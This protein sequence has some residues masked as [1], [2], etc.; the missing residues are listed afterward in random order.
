MLKTGAQHVES[1]RDG[2]SV[3]ID[4]ERVADV[5]THPAFRNAVASIATLFDFQCAPENRAL[6]SYVTEAGEPVSRAWQLPTSYAALVERR[7]GLEA[8][9]DLHYGFLNRTPDYVASGISAMVMGLD[10]FEAY[11]RK[12]AGA[13]LDYYRHARDH[14]LYLNYVITNPQADR[15]KSAG[16]QARELFTAGMVDQDHEGITVR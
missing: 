14:N 1:L 16:S 10:V 11:D 13:L 2:R 15:S 3:Y 12:R 7:K 4:G 6:L 9:A 5:T 8:I